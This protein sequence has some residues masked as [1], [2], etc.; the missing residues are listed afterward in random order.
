MWNLSVKSST[1]FPPENPVLTLSLSTSSEVIPAA[2][3]SAEEAEDCPRGK[4][5]GSSVCMAEQ[6]N[7]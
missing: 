3:S 5:Q 7:F 2:S 6:D 4:D 1:M